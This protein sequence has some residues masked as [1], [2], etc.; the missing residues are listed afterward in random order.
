VSDHYLI[1][2]LTRSSYETSGSEHE[3]SASYQKKSAFDVTSASY[4]T[5]T[6]LRVGAFNVR[7]F[8][9]S[10]VADEDVLNILVQVCRRCFI[11]I[12]FVSA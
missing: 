1:E 3:S 6:D 12:I 10:K 4:E 2:L 9:R 8:G 7:V 11:C 5:S